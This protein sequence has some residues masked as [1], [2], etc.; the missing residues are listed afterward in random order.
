MQLK[1]RIRTEFCALLRAQATQLQ[2]N[3]GEDE[4]AHI[5][6]RKIMRLLSIAQRLQSE[7]F[8]RKVLR[9]LPEF[10]EAYLDACGSTT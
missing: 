10:Y 3:A 6:S 5:V 9:E 1:S 7:T 4:D 8:L 2:K